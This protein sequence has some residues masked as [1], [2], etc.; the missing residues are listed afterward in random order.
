MS[1]FYASEIDR[2]RDITRE[3]KK[4]RREKERKREREHF[5]ETDLVHNVLFPAVHLVEHG[6]FVFLHLTDGAGVGQVSPHPLQLC[7]SEWVG[8]KRTL[9]RGDDVCEGGCIYVLKAD[10][11]QF[12]IRNVNVGA[13]D[14]VRC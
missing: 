3:R 1:S 11:R 2:E 4:E 13:A 6:Q 9:L 10:R 14:T 8:D 7:G 5:R 12:H